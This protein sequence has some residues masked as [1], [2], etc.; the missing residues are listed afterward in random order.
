[1]KKTYVK[2][3][4]EFHSCERQKLKGDAAEK[5]IEQQ[6]NRQ[7]INIG[8]LP[9]ALDKISKY[10]CCFKVYEHKKDVS[11][12]MRLICKSELEAMQRV[13]ELQSKYKEAYS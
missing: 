12:L 11:L 8:L 3:A 9:I 5:E 10:R 4:M 2:S 13:K 7:L 6:L 1:M